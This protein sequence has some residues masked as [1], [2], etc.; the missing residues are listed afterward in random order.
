[1]LKSEKIKEY[2][3]THGADDC[4]IASVERFAESPKGFAPTDIYSECK[5]VVVFA[6][7]MPVGC[8][9]GE[10]MITYNHAA[11]ELYKV[12]DKIAIETCYFIEKH[13]YN[14][15]PSF[16]LMCPTA[17]GMRKKIAGW[18]FCP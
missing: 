16:R 8:L 13:G 6:R 4:G 15:T 11:Y 18:A 14:A 5:S 10:E 1:M 9:E 2:A 7:H 17:A 12:M 3:K